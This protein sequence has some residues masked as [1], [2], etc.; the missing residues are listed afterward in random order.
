MRRH[1]SASTALFIMLLAAGCTGGNDKGNDKGAGQD[2][3]GPSAT[4]SNSAALDL[5]AK[6]RILVPPTSGTGNAKLPG[7]KVDKDVY[8]IHA[9]CVGKGKITIVY[10]NDPKDQPTPVSCN[11]PVTIGRVYTDAKSQSL[12][13]QVSHGSPRWTVAVVS[14][15][16]TM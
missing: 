13:V 14:G 8:T 3:P 6:A 15:E 5:P 2:T 16:H 10:G 7:F 4:K 1:A 12:A 9:R 11:G